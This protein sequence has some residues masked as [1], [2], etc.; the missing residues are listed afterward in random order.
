MIEVYEQ[1]KA[2]GDETRYA[3]VKQLLQ[4]NHCVGSL[5]KILKISESAVSQ[6][7]KILRVTGII[8]G[9]KKGYYSHYHVKKEVLKD[10][11]KEINELSSFTQSHLDCKDNNHISKNCC[12]KEAT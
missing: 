1:L 9:E 5:A 2:L 7:L 11:A 4:Y 8:T 10:I 6:Q 12:G 3:I